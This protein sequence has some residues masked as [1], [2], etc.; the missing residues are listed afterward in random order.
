MTKIRTKTLGGS[1]DASK[2][3]VMLEL[4]N[5]EGRCCQTSSLDNPGEE[6]RDKYKED[7]YTDEAILGNC[8]KKVHRKAR[9]AEI[10]RPFC[11][12]DWLFGPP[13]ANL[14]V[15]GPHAGD[16]GFSFII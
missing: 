6:D 4:C 9:K 2:A 15:F 12:Q 5:G 10:F 11:H 8:T 7:V 3:A 16:G 14:T 13:T 1:Y